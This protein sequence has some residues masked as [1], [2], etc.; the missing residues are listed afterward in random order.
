MFHEV[1]DTVGICCYEL[2]PLV[3][4]YATSVMDLYMN[5]NSIFIIIAFYS[6]DI[7]L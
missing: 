3:S 5:P 7:E 1:W 4:L 2:S 6:I